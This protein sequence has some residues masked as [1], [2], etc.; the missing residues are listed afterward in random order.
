MAKRSLFTFSLLTATAFLGCKDSLSSDGGG[1][2]IT[3][4]FSE[5]AANASFDAARVRIIGPTNRTINTTPGAEEVI[6]GLAPGSYRVVLEGLEGTEVELFGQQNNV[7]VTG[8][9]TTDVTVTFS[10]FIPSLDAP[11]TPS[12]T[13][14]FDV[15][16][17]AV[18]GAVGYV[19]EWD[20]DGAF[21]NPN[22]IPVTQTTGEVPGVPG[23]V[24]V[25]VRAATEFATFSAPS[26][27]QV[28]NVAPVVASVT[29]APAALD[30]L[31]G[32]GDTVQFMAQ[33]QDANG[34][35]FTGP[36]VA[37]TTS[38]AAVA[39]VNSEGAV[40]VQANGTADIIATISGIEGRGSF[41]SATIQADSTD[42][43]PYAVTQLPAGLTWDGSR[44]LLSNGGTDVGGRVYFIDPDGMFV[45]SLLIAFDSRTIIYNEA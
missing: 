38:N 43:F 29:V 23:T 9:N 16:F 42:G 1:L 39:M 27:A 45:D 14:R 8:G 10:S 34:D 36:A 26:N 2:A 28:V 30:T 24:H 44:Y 15:N 21:P 5:S 7:S 40:I 20:T 41:T 35:G 22:R 32:A 18:P 13:L 3:A 17:D 19:I 6:E 11:A 4:Q 33:P 12:P 31:I 25:R 37:W